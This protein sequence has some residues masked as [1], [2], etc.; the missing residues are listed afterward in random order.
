MIMSKNCSIFILFPTTQPPPLTT[1]THERDEMRIEIMK[2]RALCEKALRE[3][4]AAY[5]TT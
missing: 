2:E 5:V 3:R 1:V 4:L